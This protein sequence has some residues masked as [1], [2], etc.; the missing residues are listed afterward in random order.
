MGGASA[1]G[2]AVPS[3]FAETLQ[4]Q[5]GWL[6]IVSMRL[7]VDGFSLAAGIR[8]PAADQSNGKKPLRCDH[9]LRSP[10]SDLGKFAVHDERTATAACRQI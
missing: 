4:C 1:P 2:I 7:F 5:S 10:A 8:I 3:D 9:A 6:G